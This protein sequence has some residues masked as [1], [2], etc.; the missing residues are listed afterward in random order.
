VENADLDLLFQISQE[1]AKIIWEKGDE[2]S[3]LGAIMKYTYK[4]ERLT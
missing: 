2:A 1:D 4:I 3:F